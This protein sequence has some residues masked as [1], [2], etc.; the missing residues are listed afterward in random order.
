VVGAGIWTI[1]RSLLRGSE[2][3][4][5]KSLLT[6][7]FLTLHQAAAQRDSGQVFPPILFLLAHEGQFADG[8]VAAAGELR[9]AVAGDDVGL[10][11][12]LLGAEFHNGEVRH[13]WPLLA[14]G[15]RL[16]VQAVVQ[17]VHSVGGVGHPNEH[18]GSH[19]DE[20]FDVTERDLERL[21]AA[22][23]IFDGLER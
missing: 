6:F 1:G 20:G 5:C 11:G 2:S 15:Q 14:A 21:G 23:D 4:L 9:P 19:G 8:D 16:G 3:R 13:V 17:F 18:R 7:V 10:L 12:Q 22:A